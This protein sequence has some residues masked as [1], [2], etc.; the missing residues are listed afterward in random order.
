MAQENL[1]GLL[2]AANAFRNQNGESPD[3]IADLA[4]FC[5]A[6]PDRCS[7]DAGLAPGKRINGA[8]SMQPTST[9]L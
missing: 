1:Q 4:A 3:S 6:N 9:V 7:V 5:A 2:V 8:V